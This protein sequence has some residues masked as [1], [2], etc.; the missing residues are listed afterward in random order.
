MASLP[1]ELRAT[2]ID[3]ALVASLADY[4]RVGLDG[5]RDTR[6]IVG[7]GR[8][9]RARRASVPGYAV[10]FGY[11]WRWRDEWDQTWWPQGIAVGEH[12]GKPVAL[13]SWYAQGKRGV[14]QGSRI[15]FVELS[16]PRRPSYRHVL[17]VSPRQT[18][19]GVVLDPVLA[20]A[21]GIAW[22]GDRLLI[23][24]TFDGI[25]EFR[26][27][28][29]LRAHRGRGPFGYDFVLP[30]SAHHRALEPSAMQRMRYSFITSDPAA[31]ADGG[32]NLIVG[33]YGR[34]NVGRVARL[35]MSGDRSLITET[36]APGIQHMQGAAVVR[37]RTSIE[38][39]FVSAS[40]GQRSGDLWVGA[41]DN[42]R[43]L[44][45]QLPPGPEALAVWQ[46]RNQLWSVS[47]IP[48][49]RF[50]YAMDVDRL[51]AEK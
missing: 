7:V 16:D 28:D 18:D 44:A 43:N 38:T 19:A 39:W 34:D 27:G 41:I 17:L 4:T 50:I 30:E 9:A 45:G 29:I 25:R 12:G 46:N 33:E 8:P 11:R 40:N 49:K 26:L 15:S 14:E 6:G 31:A 3:D 23:A 13:V 47:E 51:T 42:L 22:I 36:Y 1:F 24:A 48:G 2:A 32:S 20:H 10:S 5:V 35:T 37:D 21:G